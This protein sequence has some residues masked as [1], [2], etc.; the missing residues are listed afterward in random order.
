VSCHLGAGAS[1]CAALGGRSVDTTMGFTP[2]EGLVMATRAGS[3]DPGLVLWLINHAGIPA[4]EVAR[5][6]EESSGLVGLAGTDDMRVVVARRDVDERARLA[7]DVYI[8][9]LVR[10][11]GAMTVALGGLD[12]LVFTG[13][14]GELAPAVRQAGAERLTYLGVALDIDRNAGYRQGDCDVSTD[15]A[16]VR[17]FV[18]AARED[19][20]IARQTREVL[21][22]GCSP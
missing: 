21:G 16:T 7:F 6:L 5:A 9:R 19:L 15:D 2:L 22:A 12:V 20:E 11:I 3:V 10:E 14:V 18:V 17:T 1:L 4:V 8:H 13:G